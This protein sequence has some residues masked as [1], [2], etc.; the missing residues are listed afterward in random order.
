[1]L[2]VTH[3]IGREQTLRSPLLAG[4]ELDLDDVFSS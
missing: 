3:T 1:M 2:E 4:L